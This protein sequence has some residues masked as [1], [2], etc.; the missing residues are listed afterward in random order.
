MSGQQDFKILEDEF[1]TLLSASR[2]DLE[3][4]RPQINDED[5]YSELIG[6]LQEAHRRMESTAQF[7]E[8]MAK[9]KGGAKTFEIGK[10]FARLLRGTSL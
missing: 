7:N 4:L 6:A 2:D 3:K 8:R 9:G 5:A 1:R 10:I